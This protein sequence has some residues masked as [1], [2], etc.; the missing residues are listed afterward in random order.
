MSTSPN[1][2]VGDL[3]ISVTAAP[4]PP[5]LE[6]VGEVDAHTCSRLKAALDELLAPGERGPDIVI[7]MAG[8]TFL[9]SSGLRVLL[10]AAKEA[11]DLGG[12]VRLRAPSD[13]VVR[14]L[15][16]T[17]LAERFLSD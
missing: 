2:E 5:V 17:G 12:H 4:G 3:R 13:G 7:D 9:D 6:V 8:V 11:E 16:I 14:L 10:G 15:E 1:P